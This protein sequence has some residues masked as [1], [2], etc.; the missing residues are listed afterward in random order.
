MKTK[1]TKTKKRATNISGPHGH[2][3]Y[4]DALRNPCFFS[5]LYTHL[6]KG[7]HREWDAYLYA[8]TIIK[9]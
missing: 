2:S 1:K 3:R 4:V 8:S 9:V 6:I 5:I 7:E